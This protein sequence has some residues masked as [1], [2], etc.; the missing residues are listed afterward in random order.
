M[1]QTALRPKYYLRQQ[2]LTRY[3][4]KTRIRLHIQPPGMQQRLSVAAGS[5]HAF[6]RQARSVLYAA[7]VFKV[8]TL[9]GKGA[10]CGAAIS[11]WR[12]VIERLLGSS[13]SFNM[14]MS[15]EPC[16]GTKCRLKT[17]PP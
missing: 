9:I 1:N 11:D 17:E 2:L 12:H 6:E 8:P 15:P 14:G 4:R 10:T 16:K 13:S 3:R 5:L 7:D